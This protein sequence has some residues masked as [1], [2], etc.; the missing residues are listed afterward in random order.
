MK[1]QN[2]N[3]AQLVRKLHRAYER[4][5]GMAE[6]NQKYAH[7]APTE[8]ERNRMLA[9]AAKQ[10]DR[11]NGYSAQLYALASTRLPLTPANAS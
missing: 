9:E 2:L 8:D 5:K 7:L 10:T 6:R 3:K 1:N 4:A 11:A